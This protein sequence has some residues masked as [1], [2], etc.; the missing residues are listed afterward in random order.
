MGGI[1]ALIH[2]INQAGDRED[3]TEPAVCALR[4]VTSRHPDAEMAQNAV[5]LHQG[6]PVMVRLLQPSSHWPLLKATVGLIR[7]LALCPA[8]QAP[9]RDLQAI[10]V[11]AQLLVKSFQ[12]VQA[13]QKVG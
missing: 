10:P 6:L 3:I 7:N 11:V 5:R 8:N 9:L 12:E 1:E 13:A 4:H 2:T